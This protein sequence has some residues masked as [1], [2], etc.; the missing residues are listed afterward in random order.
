MSSKNN[1][2]KNVMYEQQVKHLPAQTIDNLVDLIENKLKP[3]MYGVVLHDKDIDEQGQPTEP[4]VHAMLCFDNA[5]SLNS[6]AKQLGDKPQYIEAWRGNKNNG[7]AY[8]CHRTAD[9]KDKYQYKPEDVI[10][11][12]DYPVL[13]QKISAEVA[14]SNSTSIKLLLDLLY[15]GSISKDEVEEHL[16]GSQYG[17]FKNQIENVYAKYL[18]N[19]AEQFRK[20]MIEQNKSVKVIWIYGASGTGKTSLAKEYAEK[21]EQEYFV[22]GSSRDIFQNYKG[23]HTLIMDELRP[24]V[25]PYADLLRI[26]DPYENN[27]M[28]PAR[29][30][31]KALAC[32]LI[33]ITTPYNPYEFYQ[34]IFGDISTM[35]VYARRKLATDSFEQLL[36][37]LS[38]VIEMNEYWI[39]AVEYDS[40]TGTFNYIKNAQ[41]KNVYSA[42]NRQSNAVNP[43]DLF[44]SIFD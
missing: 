37:R 43:V 21:A 38:L 17:R 13:L 6:V 25:I 15:N 9:A 34:E 30:H 36:R 19:Q 14:N 42:Q 44:N 23:E 29:Y 3:K 22:T 35:P 4:H 31:D 33:I 24:N 10:A 1:S 28:L 11:N 8:L 5:R 40:K 12:F 26:L 32:D 2:Y 7:F 39:N 41:K 18:Q 20:K 27:K 16:T